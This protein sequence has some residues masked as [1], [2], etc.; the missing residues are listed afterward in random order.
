[1][2]IEPTVGAA[3]GQTVEWL[4]EQLGA[5]SEAQA[6]LK[7]EVE[8]LRRQVQFVAEQSDA[9][10]R[11]VAQ[12]DPKILPYRGLPE[13]VAALNE[14]AEHTRQA[15]SANQGEVEAALRLRESEARFDRQE[16]AET[17][18]RIEGLGGRLDLLAADSARLGTQISQ[19]AQALNMVP[20]Q[21]R[22]TVEQVAQFGLRLDRIAEV[23]QEIE[24]RLMAAITEQQGPPIDVIHERLQLLGEMIRRTE[25]NI[26]QLFTAQHVGE[27]VMQELGVRRDEHGRIETRISSA[28][29]TIESLLRELDQ[30]RGETTLLD[31]RHSGLSERVG[32]IRRDIAEV[33]DHVRAEFTKFGA[34]Q[35]KQRRKQIEVLEQELRELKFHTLRPPDEP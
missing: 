8:Q 33:I 14:D 3:F 16:L 4:E 20:D 22:E 12:V 32:A 2:T 28:E 7:I 29:G 21:L 9:A 23:N 11:S 35:E 30:V 15:I 13:K 27:E 25:E 31:G 5:H 10:E 1:M 24:A 6:A 26:E 18:K 34:M 19:I 17:V